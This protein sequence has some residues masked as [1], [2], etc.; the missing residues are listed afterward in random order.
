[1]KFD[2]GQAWNDAVSLLRANGQVVTVVAGV[3]F[4]LPNV[5]LMM[6]LPGVTEE[7]ESRVAGGADPEAALQALGALY[8]QIWW[9]ILLVSLITA[10]GMLGLLALL[11]D[12]GRP[13]VGEALKSG[14]VYLLPYI[15][16]QLLMTFIILVTALALALIAQVAGAAVG[17]LLGVVAAVAMIYIYVKFSLT[18]PVIVIEK[19][20][21][22]V[23]A[24]GRSWALTKGHSIRLFVFY[25]LLFIALVVIAL[26]TGLIAGLLGALTSPVLVSSLFNAAV[27]AIAIVVYL[28]VVAA[29]HRQLSGGTGETRGE[30]FE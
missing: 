14:L 25:L 1:M 8:G 4:F 16:S 20:A 9:Q 30:P 27:N 13:T 21:N 3:F 7:A 5:A 23:R 29:I 24:L 19:V 28:A 17:A 22:P 18:V 10:I 6:M 15:G 26:V 12:R 2:M 11:T